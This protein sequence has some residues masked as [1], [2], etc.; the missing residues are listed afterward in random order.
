MYD[1]FIKVNVGILEFIL[2]FFVTLFLKYI[3]K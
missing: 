1:F 2:N 3:K